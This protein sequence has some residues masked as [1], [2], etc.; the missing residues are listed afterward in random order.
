MHR[1]R[2]SP[3]RDGRSGLL[4]VLRPRWD[5]MQQP[6]SNEEL[7]QVAQRHSGAHSFRYTCSNTRCS[8][9]MYSYKSERD[10]EQTIDT[11]YRIYKLCVIDHRTSVK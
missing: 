3:W 10:S 8:T 7:L 11:K 4:L 9:D 5:R 1:R 6:A 2:S